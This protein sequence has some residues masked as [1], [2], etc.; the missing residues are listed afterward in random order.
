MKKIIAHMVFGSIVVSLVSGCQLFITNFD[1]YTALNGFYRTTNYSSTLA[2]AAYDESH[3]YEGEWSIERDDDLYWF[4]NTTTREQIFR[5]E[6]GET[7]LQYWRYDYSNE[8]TVNESFNSK[9]LLLDTSVIEASWFIVNQDN[10][11]LYDAKNSALEKQFTLFVDE[12]VID[13]VGEDFEYKFES[14]SI[15]LNDD[16][17]LKEVNYHISFGE[18]KGV[19]ISMRF[20]DFGEVDFVRPL[21]IDYPLL[22]SQYNYRVHSGLEFDSLTVTKDDQPHYNIVLDDRYFR[23]ETAFNDEIIHGILAFGNSKFL[24]LT[25]DGDV[26]TSFDGN[27]PFVFMPPAL[28]RIAKT[29]NYYLVSEDPLRFRIHDQVAIDW[30]ND[31]QG[32]DIYGVATMPLQITNMEIEYRKDAGEIIVDFDRTDI[33]GTHHWK[34][35]Y[36][37]YTPQ[38]LEAPFTLLDIPVDVLLQLFHLQSTQHVEI[39]AEVN[40]IKLVDY[41]MDLQGDQLTINSSSSA[42]LPSILHQISFPATEA[43]LLENGM[44]SYHPIS[45]PTETIITTQNEFDFPLTMIDFS[46]WDSDWFYPIRVAESRKVKPTAYDSFL[47]LIGYDYVYSERP[48]SIDYMNLSY[49]KSGFCVYVKAL[50]ELSAKIEYRICYSLPMAL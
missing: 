39:W 33:T 27:A 47:P 38:V 13:I 24:A 6:S 21:A 10:P 41:T 44:I 2:Y 23:L 18:E 15:E 25:Y 8:F 20:D 31:L 32:S 17:T 36:D 12:S 46:L 28:T 5:D 22:V 45:S 14:F 43:L 49:D 40:D 16:L 30:I 29:N 4:E 1:L 48:A 34:F 26:I 37:L 19:E 50:S 3:R 7:D 35:F 42:G 11:H 9:E